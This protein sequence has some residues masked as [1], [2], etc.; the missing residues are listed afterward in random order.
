M[1]ISGHV[2]SEIASTLHF[3]LYISVFFG[4]FRSTMND[5]VENL[6]MRFKKNNFAA[7]FGNGS[8]NIGSPS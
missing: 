3:T 6:R 8:N 1:Q 7:S 5:Q 4:L 2:Q